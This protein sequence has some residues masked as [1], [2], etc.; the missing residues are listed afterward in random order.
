VV[1]LRLMRVLGE[2]ACTSR[3][4]R[5]AIAIRDEAQRLAD[6]CAEGYPPDDRDRLNDRREVVDRA[7]AALAAGE[8]RAVP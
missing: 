1:P 8:P 5:D 2:L 3:N 6:A 7:D 4:L